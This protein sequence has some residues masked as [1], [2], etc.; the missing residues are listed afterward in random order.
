MLL[1]TIKD[2]IHV[3]GLQRRKVFHIGQFFHIFE[4]KLC[5]FVV[6]MSGLVHDVEAINGIC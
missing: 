3:Q 5:F 6:A 1:Y 4:I 2:L